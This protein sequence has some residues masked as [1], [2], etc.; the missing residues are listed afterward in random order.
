LL[1]ILFTQYRAA[2][3]A[4]KQTGL[5]LCSSAYT[6]ADEWQRKEGEAYARAMEAGKQNLNCFLLPRNISANEITE[7]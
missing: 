5:S 2:L 7:Q 1:I 6:A 4:E 3:F